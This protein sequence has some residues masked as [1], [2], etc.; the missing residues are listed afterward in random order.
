MTRGA[1]EAI[2]RTPQ[3]DFT[4]ALDA[5]IERCFGAEEEEEEGVIDKLIV[6]GLAWY[7][8]TMLMGRASDGAVVCLGSVGNEAVTKRYLEEHPT[9][10]TW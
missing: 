9:P 4:A 3:E 2:G 6:A 8:G 10:E 5:W 7:E 1:T